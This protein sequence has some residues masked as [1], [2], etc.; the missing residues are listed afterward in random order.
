MMPRGLTQPVHAGKSS[1]D[2]ER[3][4]A[5]AAGP[6]GRAGAPRQR[7]VQS[8]GRRGLRRLRPLERHRFSR[9]GNRQLCRNRRHLRRWFHRNGSCFDLLAR[10]NRLRAQRLRRLHARRRVVH[11]DRVRAPT[12]PPRPRPRARPCPLCDFV[13]HLNKVLKMG[14]ATDPRRRSPSE[15]R[16]TSRTPASR[17]PRSTGWHRPPGP[18][19]RRSLGTSSR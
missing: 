2:G 19:M 4:A 7:P 11:R 6:R 8:P 17:R 5:S 18:T 12:T 10:R 13:A 15:G 16:S 3:P 1:R 9:P 14:F